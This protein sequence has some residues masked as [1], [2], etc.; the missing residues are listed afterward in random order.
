MVIWLECE[1]EQAIKDNSQGFSLGDF[2]GS[3]N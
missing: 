1:G 3:G 2:M